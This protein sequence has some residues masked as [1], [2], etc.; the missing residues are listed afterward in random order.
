MSLAK[1][2]SNAA[3]GLS[4]V[5][6]GTGVVSDNLANIQTPGFA[7]REMVLQARSLGGNGGGVRI[8][9]ISRVVNAGLLAEQRLAGAARAEASKRLEFLQKV[10]DVIGVPGSVGGLGEALTTF[11]T[12]LLDASGRPEDENR[13][14][15]LA[16]SAIELTSR[17]NTVSD[18]VQTARTDADAAIALDVKTLND[19]LARVAYLNRRISSVG[20]Q[21]K[22][23]SP[24]I[25]E[26]QAIIDQVNVIVPVQEIARGAGNVALFT[27]SGAPLLDGTK[28]SQIEFE[29]AP[30]LSA[31]LSVE[32]GSIGSLIVDGKVLPASR[33][34][35]F[36]GGTLSA[37]FEIRDHLGPQ[38]QQELD[39]FVLE[40]HDRFA[41]P[42]VDSTI[43]ADALGLFVDGGEPATSEKMKGLAAR[44]ALNPVV[45]PSAGG[46]LWR[47]RDGLGAYEA[48]PTGDSSLLIG[49]EN[50]LSRGRV[51][52]A[53]SVF[54][55]NA[56]LGRRLAT[57][58]SRV[59]SRRNSAETDSALKNSQADA[60]SERFLSDGVNSDAELQRL[61]EYGQAYAANARVI[62]AIDEMMDQV[63][64]W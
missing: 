45:D 42:T 64:R 40:L 50:A 59:I 15:N 33:M 52:P 62:Q 21:G 63:L 16:Q 36:S 8:D 61:L 2:L 14:L 22:D 43:A 25:D 17:L 29:P 7:R 12:R 58:E 9:N 19:G 44:I 26:R 13:L 60:I 55:E 49:L 53:G 5:A 37:N 56:S 1:A 27:I 3:T 51:P 46:E 54:G 18:I 38:I 30:R 41:D 34:H 11:Q 39:S 24:L 10:E 47:L 35:F 28:P 6:R 32:N 4:A 23:P 31:E 20:S 57:L 48:G